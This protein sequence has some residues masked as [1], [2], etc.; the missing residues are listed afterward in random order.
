MAESRRF[1]IDTNVVIAIIEAPGD[2]TPGQAA[3]I[4]DVDRARIMAITSE[5]TLAECLVKPMAERNA[6]TVAA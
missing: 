2:L 1:Y 4:D 6:G 3:F 5:L